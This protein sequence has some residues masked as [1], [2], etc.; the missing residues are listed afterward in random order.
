MLMGG[1]KA[2]RT[3][4]VPLALPLAIPALFFI[5]SLTSFFSRFGTEA[6]LIVLW[7]LFLTAGSLLGFRYIV[8]LP[9]Q[10]ADEKRMVTMPGS[11]LPLLLSLTIFTLKFSSGVI[12]GYFPHLNGSVAFLVMEL[13][14][15]TAL[16]FFAGRGI[17]CLRRYYTLNDTD[18]KKSA[19]KIQ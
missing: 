10:F 7:V 15:A 16:G 8:R 1:L 14:A 6:K 4:T 9:L 18:N 12:G 19:E 3:H 17:G 5:W 2:R 13:I 11:L